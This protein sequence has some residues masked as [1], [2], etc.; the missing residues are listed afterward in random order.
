[1]NYKQNKKVKLAILA[2]GTGTTFESIAMACKTG[3]LSA[4]IVCLVSDRSNISVLDKADNYGVPS[5]V[6]IQKDYSSIEEWDKVLCNYL[7]QKKPDWV[8]LA[9]FLKKIETA[10]LK[11]FKNRII[12]THP[13]LLPK[14]GGKGMYGKHVHQAVIESGDKTTGV[15]VHLVSEQYDRGPI[16]AQTPVS[17][18]P[19]DTA[20]SLESKVKAI[21]KV[22]Y[23]SVLQQLISGKM[24]IKEIK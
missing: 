1:M 4:D 5:K 22:F 17:V 20:E 15:S 7:H 13:A 24:K 12:N 6:I 21:E 2:S 18:S 14:Y 19:D 23:V 3:I 8:V 10:T 16:L 11:Q 9:G